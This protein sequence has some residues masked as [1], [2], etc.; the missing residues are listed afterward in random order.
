MEYF[1]T[2]THFIKI[3]SHVSISCII[4]F[5]QSDNYKQSNNLPDIIGK[6]GSDVKRDCLFNSIWL[7]IKQCVKKALITSSCKPKKSI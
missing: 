6:K 3:K 5:N 7:S 2:N 1:G 4:A